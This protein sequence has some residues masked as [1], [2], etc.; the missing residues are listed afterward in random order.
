MKNAII[1]CFFVIYALSCTGEA[2]AERGLSEAEMS[3]SA[4]HPGDVDLEEAPEEK[5]NRY[6]RIMR[7]LN[8]EYQEGSLTK[9]EYI[10]RKRE[11]DNLDL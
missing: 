4:D 7:D 1:F 9:T 3:I 11:I 6:K 2:R 8:R 10:Q 5:T